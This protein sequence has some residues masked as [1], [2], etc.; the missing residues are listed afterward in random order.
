[1]KS[2]A[3]LLPSSAGEHIFSKLRFAIHQEKQSFRKTRDQAELG[4][5]ET[6]HHRH[7]RLGVSVRSVW[8]GP[9]V[10]LDRVSCPAGAVRSDDQTNHEPALRVEVGR[11][12]S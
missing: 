10:Q 9:L 7:A 8:T 12:E 11:N 4:H 1:M 2:L 6:G 5:E 3:T